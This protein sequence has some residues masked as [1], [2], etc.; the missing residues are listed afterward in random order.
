MVPVSATGG[1][2]SARARRRGV[3]TLA[4]LFAC[5]VPWACGEGTPADHDNDDLDGVLLDVV[6]CGMRAIARRVHVHRMLRRQRHLV[7]V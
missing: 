7:R 4:L 2:T 1:A 5:A 3:A 6:R